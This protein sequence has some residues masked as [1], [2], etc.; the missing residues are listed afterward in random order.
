[1]TCSK[2]IV[3]ILGLVAM[4]AACGTPTPSC[5]GGAPVD[6]SCPVANPI[7]GTW[8]NTTVSANDM[9]AGV[10]SVQASMTF[11][12]MGVFSFATTKMFG[13]TASAHAGCT[14]A[15][16][17]TGA[18][19]LSGTNTI[20]ML[21]SAATVSYSNC[22]SGTDNVAQTALTTPQLAAVNTFLALANT[23][24]VS[25]SLLTLSSITDAGMSSAGVFTRSGM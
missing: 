2:S 13:T 5:D 24:T 14:E 20:S 8:T 3:G 23:Y 9:A 21:L 11:A 19:T 18:Y 6:G 25:G 1:M 15:I 12:P 17:G 7:E 4:L 10:T 22:A 16:S